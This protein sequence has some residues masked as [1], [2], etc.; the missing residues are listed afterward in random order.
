MPLPH[1]IGLQV[2]AE[3]EPI[4]GFCLDHLHLI[5][6]RDGPRVWPVW[7]GALVTDTMPCSVCGRTLGE[8][9]QERL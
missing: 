8:I 4:R 9:A 5:T 1:V 6:E 3:N 2:D 7:S